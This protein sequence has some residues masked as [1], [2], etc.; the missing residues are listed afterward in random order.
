MATLPACDG[1]GVS[2]Q[3]KNRKASSWMQVQMEA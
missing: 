2:E 3:N 1:W